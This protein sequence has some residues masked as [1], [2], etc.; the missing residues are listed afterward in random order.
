MN[1]TKNTTKK[2]VSLFTRLGKAFIKYGRYFLGILV[3]LV[4]GLIH[5]FVKVIKYI[6]KYTAKF[7]L[8]ALNKVTKAVDYLVV[9]IVKKIIYLSRVL[10][11]SPM[12][13]WLKHN[14]A[15]LFKFLKLK[16]LKLYNAPLTKR[17]RKTALA[18]FV[19]KILVALALRVKRTWKA[20]W[21]SLSFSVSSLKRSLIK[22]PQLRP[23]F[24]SL[25][26]VAMVVSLFLPIVQ[27]RATTL[28]WSKNSDFG[29]NKAGKC[30]Q[31]TMTNLALIGATNYTDQTCQAAD[32]DAQLSLAKD[33]N[34]VGSLSDVKDIVQG[35][36]FSLAV[37]ND[38]TV[39]AW[40]RNDTGQ[41]GD[42]TQTYRLTPVQVKDSTG[43][44]YLNN[45][46]SVAAAGYFLAYAVKNDGT[47]WRW[48][49]YTGATMLP[50]QVADST[51]NGF[52]SNIASVEAGYNV[53]SNNLITLAL[54]NDGTVWAWG[55]G[56]WGENGDGTTTYRGSPTQVKDSTGTGYLTNIT[57][58][59]AEGSHC[60]ALRNDGTVWGWGLND[61]VQIGDGTGT[62]RL[63]PV[64]V[65]SNIKAISAGQLFGIAL[66]NDGVA[67]EW[68]AELAPLRE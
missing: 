6:A 15:Q 42:G 66:D 47:V 51:G 63:L 53:Y 31:T 46:K 43:T 32:A 40:G 3:Y 24:I 41:M 34:S 9:Y 64:L 37:K 56:S 65:K 38:G 13:L 35:D 48:G 36:G 16:L 39:W 33:P 26:L 62:N 50:V 17:L 61:Q 29:M 44:G 59:S 25:V 27:V 55:G 2:E 14:V 23:V 30:S 54:S 11:N 7:M 20:F 28:Q 22:R 60:M 4:R 8:I 57:S 58:I 45:V 12:A 19:R 68:V 10:L 52:L 18:Q 49:A 21:I 1:N 67:W 5:V